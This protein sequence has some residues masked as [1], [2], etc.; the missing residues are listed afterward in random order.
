MGKGILPDLLPSVLILNLSLR[1]KNDTS[2]Q[3]PADEK[4][5]G[6]KAKFHKWRPLPF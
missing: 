2:Q 3:E 1:A 5:E 6:L 4:R